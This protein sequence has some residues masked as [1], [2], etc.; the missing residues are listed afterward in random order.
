MN[1]TDALRWVDAHSVNCI[2]CDTLFDERVGVPGPGHVGDV[3]PDC[4]KAGK[5]GEAEG[6]E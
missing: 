6:C 3:C 2:Y 1:E 5:Q 4:L